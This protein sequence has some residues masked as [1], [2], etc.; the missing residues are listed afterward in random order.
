MGGVRVRV[1]VGGG[2]MPQCA[3]SV[4]CGKTKCKNKTESA[5]SLENTDVKLAQLAH[6]FVCQ[7]F[8]FSF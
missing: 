7:H 6:V 5:E 3:N 1:G 4:Q 8:F 2:L